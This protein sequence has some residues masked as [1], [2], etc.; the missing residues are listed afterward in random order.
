VWA[1][2]AIG[3]T[4]AGAGLAMA[5]RR[6][7]TTTGGPGAMPAPPPPAPPPPGVPAEAEVPPAHGPAEDDPQAALDAARDRLR[8]RADE[9]RREIEDTGPGTPGGG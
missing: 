8:N 7:P 5:R 3:A 2:S 4:A 1:A 6:R 9:L